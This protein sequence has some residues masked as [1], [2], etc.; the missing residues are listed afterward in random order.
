[1]SYWKYDPET[2]SY[3]GDSGPQLAIGVFVLAAITIG[4]YFGVNCALAFAAVIAAVAARQAPNAKGVAPTR[5]S[6]RSKPIDLE[7]TDIAWE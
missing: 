6:G 4:V 3:S 2:R 1:M 5:L 7:T